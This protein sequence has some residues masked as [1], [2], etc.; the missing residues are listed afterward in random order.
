[1]SKFSEKL[2]VEDYIIKKLQE[3][4]WIYKKSKEL[5]RESYEEPLLIQ[6]LEEAI[7]RINKDADLTPLD[8]T[9]VLN[10]LQGKIPGAE[11][12]KKILNYLKEG[13]PIK[14]EKTNQL[15]YIRLIDYE[16]IG[17]NSFIVSNQVEYKGKERIVA[18]I[19]LYVNGIPL[20]V[21]ECKDPTDPSVSWEDAY[22]QIKQYEK[23]VEELFKYIQFSIAAE[24]NV[25]YFPSVSWLDEVETDVW[26]EEG[27]TEI[28]S[29]VEMLTREKLLDL[30]KNF[31]FIRT[32]KGKI[33]RVIARYMQ[34]RAANKIYERVV[35]TLKEIEDK[36][37]GLIWH[38]QGSGKTL[39]MIFAAYKLYN[40]K[41]LENPTLFFILD[42]KELENQ[43]FQEIAAL[44]LG[45][46]PERVETIENL[47]KIL[48][49][50]EGRGKRGFIVTL[51]HKFSQKKLRDLK[52]FLETT[53]K[54]RES[55]LTRKNIIAFV[56][57]SHRT[58]YGM[59]AAQMKS[60]LKNAFFFGFSGTPIAKKG[61]DT[62]LE[63][64][65]PYDKDYY[66]DRYFIKES[67]EDNFTLPIA[68]KP[69]PDKLLLKKELLRK[70][71]AEAEEE[72]PEKLKGRLKRRLRDVR[73]FLE[74]KD[75]IKKVA[76]DIVDHFQKN[77]D[78][79]FKAMV[80]TVSRKACIYYKRA[81]DNLLPDV[82]EIV[83]TFERDDPQE[84]F[85]YYEEL[86]ERFK[87]KEIDEILKE[88]IE[89]FKHEDTPKI[90]IV[91][92]ML[93][94]GFDAPIL[95]V[96]YLDKPLK[97]HR[98]LQAIARTNRPL[99]ER[100]KKC[101]M[102][103][104][105]IGIIKELNKALQ[106]Y[107]KFEMQDLD[108]GLKK[109][110]DFKQDFLKLV[111]E[112]KEILGDIEVKFGDREYLYKILT[113]IVLNKKEKE[114]SEKYKELRRLFELL[115]PS[116]IKLDYYDYFKF[117]TAIYII[118]LKTRTEYEAERELLQAWYKRIVEAIYK[119]TEIEA[120]EKSFPPIK[121]D[122]KYVEEIE[123]NLKITE[124]K[125]FNRLTVIRYV[126]R[127]KPRTPVYESLS[128][129]VESLIKMWI[130]RKVQTK[131]VYE[132]LKKIFK[133][134]IFIDEKKEKLGLSD[135][136]YSIL[137][138]LEE[139]FKGRKDLIG[140]VKALYKK[141]EPEI[142]PGWEFKKTIKSRIEKEIRLFLIKLSPK[143]TKGER[144]EISKKIISSLE[145]HKLS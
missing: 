30:L 28:E 138:I 136:E 64:A 48:L 97:G 67:I 16:N 49:Y 130:E 17:N 89:K 58:Q 112:M 74:D 93:L 66:L 71:L 122:E 92:D 143:I 126:L 68:Y 2:L 3:K 91:T 118:Y 10:E 8:V 42:R 53:L 27:K 142:S 100:D 41:L 108:Y 133:E 85:E 14:L 128:D 13:I 81:L 106:F 6:N 11:A 45:I 135:A 131:K 127:D 121:L 21:I 33:T 29:I 51:V 40:E 62:F 15:K 110:E 4:G 57:E 46:K 79:K 22:K 19:V 7:K 47:K 132:E 83:M 145:K 63:F 1:M 56:D 101:G 18:D 20:V 95:Q 134:I 80:V 78:G 52:Q 60:I 59:L 139:K 113:R 94:T 36:K 115:G 50:D 61:R 107:S 9:H 123:K 111:E 35:N 137:T 39:T 54:G 65:Y 124:S 37:R 117:L 23:V 32:E 96:M 76:E 114:F 38:W 98:L 86:R 31:I 43:I 69:A 109:F 102:I 119:T 12:A 77:I 88:I 144:D 73:I 72:I 84:I 125:V 116:E 103:V 104:D 82:S 44:D 25:R 26:R 70:F 140:S 141:I 90:L 87:N 55:V 5:N 24:E 34:Y 99:K 105:Y 75:R 129:R 120:I